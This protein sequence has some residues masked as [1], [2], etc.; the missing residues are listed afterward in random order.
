MAARAH[1]LP[2]VESSSGATLA[3]PCAALRGVV[4]GIYPERP[5]CCAD[6]ECELLLRVT[7]QRMSFAEARAII[8]K[9]RACRSRVAAVT[10]RAPW[11]VAHRSALV[12]AR[13]HPS[14]AVDHAELIADLE[15]LERLI[16]VHFWG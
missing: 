11:W 8:E 1:R 5:E 4:C 10:G 14:W 9:T 16:R 13:S 15:A 7:Y 12:A 3:L 6:Y 2:V